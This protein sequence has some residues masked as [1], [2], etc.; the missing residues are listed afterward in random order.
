MPVSRRARAEHDNPI[1][2]AQKIIG[3]V[4]FLT[5]CDF[6]VA[7]L[8]PSTAAIQTDQTGDLSNVHNFVK[9]FVWGPIQSIYTN[10]LPASID[11]TENSYGGKKPFFKDATQKSARVVR[12]GIE[13]ESVPREPVFEKC[14]HLREKG[15]VLTQI[16]A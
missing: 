15:G 11:L 16:R 8:A 2:R 13:I 3:G 12:C 10:N 14:P 7:N 4:A 1:S 5:K 6:V 9:N